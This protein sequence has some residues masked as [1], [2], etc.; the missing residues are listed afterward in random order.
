MCDG[1]KELADRSRHLLEG[2]RAGRG[3]GGSAVHLKHVKKTRPHCD[4]PTTCTCQH[5]RVEDGFV[6]GSI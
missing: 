5:R 1:C 6:R 3:T 4:Y 2:K